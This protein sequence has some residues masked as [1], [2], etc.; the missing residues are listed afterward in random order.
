MVRC[1]G[2]EEVAEGR[3]FVEV[4]A[5]EGILRDRRKTESERAASECRDSHRNSVFE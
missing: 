2:E 3:Q 1:G 5:S 4:G